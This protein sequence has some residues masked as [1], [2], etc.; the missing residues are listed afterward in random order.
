M[1]EPRLPDSVL[2]SRL[3][4]DLDIARV[5]AV[6]GAV[7]VG[8]RIRVDA[9]QAWS[10]GAA[11]T[12]INRMAEQ[13]LEYVEQ[14]VLA[15]NLEEMSEVRR[16][17]TV[18]ILAHEAALT[19]V[20]T[21]N[22]IKHQAADAI[23]LDPRFDVGF[24]GARAAASIAEVAGLPVVTHTFGELGVATAAIL[25]LVASHPNFILDNQTYYWNLED[26][27]IAGGLLPFD[28]PFLDV[29]TR[30]GLGVELD[31]ERVS[32]Y[33]AYYREEVKDRPIT[34]PDDGYYDRQ[35]LLRPRF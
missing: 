11:K 35:Y 2:Q 5:R 17:V 7:G 19:V 27:I 13:D 25:Q 15:S 28:G 24:T 22:V 9:N 21:L 14:P 18:P 30:P 8:P 32:H 31:S 6:R 29:P 23:Q 10:P 12:I 34:I 3:G 1:G 16:A 20:D 33:A 26:D 4:A